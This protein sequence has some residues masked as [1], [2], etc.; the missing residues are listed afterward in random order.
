MIKKYVFWKK[1]FTTPCILPNAGHRENQ[2]H[3]GWNKTSHCNTH[4]PQPETQVLRLSKKKKKKKALVKWQKRV[5]EITLKI[6]ECNRVHSVA[7]L[8]RSSFYEAQKGNL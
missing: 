6:A 8:C 5:T 1:R 3:D 2:V 4:G 7:E